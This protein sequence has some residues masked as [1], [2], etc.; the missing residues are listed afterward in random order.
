MA[1]VEI[2][3]LTLY[4]PWASAVA[5]GRKKIENR[6]W[7]PGQDLLRQKA[8]LAIHAGTVYDDRGEEFLGRFGIQ[9]PQPVVH[10]AILG[11]CRLVGCVKESEDPMFFG[12]PYFGWLLS[13][14]HELAQPIPCRGFQGTW[15]LT[16]ELLAAVK[17][18]TAGRITDELVSGG[19]SQEGFGF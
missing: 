8:Y 12:P 16:P 15:G 19:S 2:R 18:A 7:P 17:A 4:Q 13:D 6:G 1:K 3:G 14:F 5:R 10:G 9:I 11:V